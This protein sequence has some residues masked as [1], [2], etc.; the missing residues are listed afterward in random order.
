MSRVCTGLHCMLTADSPWG[1]PQAPALPEAELT[2]RM[3]SLPGTA[4]RTPVNKRSIRQ[5][6][7]KAQRSL[8]R[9][10]LDRDA[11]S[12]QRMETWSYYTGRSEDTVSPSKATAGDQS[13]GARSNLELAPGYQVKAPESSPFR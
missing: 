7:P 6:T 10:L 4:Q 11:A 2:N 9:R 5:D 13:S 1:R 3:V 8:P 12:E